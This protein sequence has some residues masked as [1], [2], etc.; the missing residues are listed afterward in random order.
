MDM[1]AGRNRIS[2]LGAF[3]PDSARQTMSSSTRMP[4]RYPSVFNLGG[5]G[6]CQLKAEKRMPGCKKNTHLRSRSFMPLTRFCVYCTI[7]EKRNAK[8]EAE[9]SAVRVL[10]RFRS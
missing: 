3:E 9:T 6:H 2:R 10:F 8:A 7:S 4:I 1:R 5:H